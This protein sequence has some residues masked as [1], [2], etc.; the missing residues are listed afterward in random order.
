MRSSRQLLGICLKRY[1]F[2]PN[3]QAVRKSTFVDVPLEIGLPHFI[4]DDNMTEDGPVFGNFKLSLQSA[5]CHRG[6]RVDSG[7]YIG[8]VRAF[9]SGN[10]EE[11]RWLRH[12]DLA[13]E[14]VAE[15]NIDSFLCEETPYLLFY[16]VVPID[17]DPGNIMDGEMFTDND[18]PPAYSEYWI[19]EA[20]DDPDRKFSYDPS[21][22]T[23]ADTSD[24]ALGVSYGISE[25]R[26]SSN[27]DPRQSTSLTDVSSKTAGTETGPGTPLGGDGLNPLTIPRRSSKANGPA[28]PN[29]S[30]TQ[31]EGNRISASMSRLAGRLAR[32]RPE[33]PAQTSTTAFGGPSLEVR[34]EPGANDKGKLKKEKSKSKLKD[35]QHLSKGR[36]KFEKPDRECI[37]M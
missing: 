27:S 11:A 35:H 33:N 25:R 26:T 9:H 22:G 21:M 31:P 24:I 30:A 13:K 8:L 3:G 29:G 28:V 32:D 34:E 7:H 15:V 23:H 5:V 37:V 16:Q 36:G 20:N 2:L 18:H 17:G 19:K 4:Q 1:S 12:D 6:T 10:P 14:R